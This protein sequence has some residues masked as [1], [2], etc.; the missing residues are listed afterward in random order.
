M[1]EPHVGKTYKLWSERSDR[2]FKRW[3]NM[4]SYFSP[5][6]RIAYFISGIIL[7]LIGVTLL[8]SGS[9]KDGI[10]FLFIGLGIIILIVLGSMIKL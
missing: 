9:Y 3:L 6:F 2:D 1:P 7:I 10:I 4:R 5:L 8:L